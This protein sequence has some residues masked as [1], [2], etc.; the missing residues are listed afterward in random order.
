MLARLLALDVRARCLVSVVDPPAVEAAFAAGVGAGVAVS[1][2]GA[3]DARYNQPV[4][5]S[6]RVRVLSDGGFV[7][8]GK[9]FTGEEAS[10]GRAA[11]V[12]TSGGI[13]VLLMEQPVF[14]TDPSYYRSVGLEPSHARIVVVK[15]A[16]QFR[17]GYGDFAEEL[18]VVD[19]AGPSPANLARL[20]WHHLTRP[21]YPFDDDFEPEL[22]TT[23]GSHR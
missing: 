19:T 17:D 8:A 20:D 13:A 6:G 23:V 14:T 21:L 18:W 4:P 9:E 2:G 16:L 3:I 10:M 15:S 22:R 5:L 7:Y 1:V 12:E 11:V